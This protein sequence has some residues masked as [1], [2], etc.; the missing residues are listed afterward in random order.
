MGG[1]LEVCDWWMSC[2]LAF[3]WFRNSYKPSDWF[4]FY[5]E[6]FDRFAYC[7][8]RYDWYT[9]CFKER[10][11]SSGWSFSLCFIINSKSSLFWLCVFREISTL[12]SQA[13]PHSTTSQ[14][15]VYITHMPTIPLQDTTQSHY[16]NSWRP[17]VV[18]LTK[19]FQLWVLFERS[20]F[21]LTY[22]WEVGIFTVRVGR[23]F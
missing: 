8:E 21:L 15:N 20:R 19:S 23:T 12:T 18:H 3:H 13:S 5:Y 9:L 22:C 4:I 1:G 14:P 17:P 6:Q 10:Y 16:I 2:S 11:I 7:Y